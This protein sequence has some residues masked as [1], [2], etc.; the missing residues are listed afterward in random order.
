MP[1][2]FLISDEFAELKHEQPEFPT[3]SKGSQYSTTSNE[4]LSDAVTWKS[5]T[6]YD[7]SK[8]KNTQNF[9]NGSLNH[10]LEG[11]LNARG[12]AVGFHYKGMPAQKGSIISGTESLPNANGIYTAR[13]G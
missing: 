7:I 11:E 13:R 2:L 5:Q 1:H 6:M 8:L 4:S 9:K 10:I 3:W 12:K